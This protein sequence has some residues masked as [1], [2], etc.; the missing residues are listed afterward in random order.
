MIRECVIIGVCSDWWVGWVEWVGCVGWVGAAE[1]KTVTAEH[2]AAGTKVTT[3]CLVP[4]PIDPNNML[5]SMVIV[6]FAPGCAS[7]IEFHIFLYNM[8]LKCLIF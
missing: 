5:L 8:C 1:G 6:I 4:A 3:S 7:L 2:A